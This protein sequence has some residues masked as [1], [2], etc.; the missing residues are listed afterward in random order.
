MNNIITN[1]KLF[2]GKNIQNLYHILDVEK[3]YYVLNNNE[4][5]SYKFS[6][7][8]TTRNKLMIDYTGCPPVSIFKLE[9]DGQKLSDNYKIKSFQDKGFMGSGSER[10]PFYHQEW[11]EQIQT[12][13]IKNVKKYI[14]KIILMKQKIESLKDISSWFENHF[15]T[16]NKKKNWISLPNILKDIIYKYNIDLWVQDG[17]V[18]KKDDDYVNSIINYDNRTVYHGFA[19]YWRTFIKK[20]T[21]YGYTDLIMPL[22]EN[23]K[24][25]D[26]LVV[27]YLYNNIWVKNHI[28]D[29]DKK[30]ITNRP[31]N[32][33]GDV[34]LYIFDFEYS[35]Q[36]IIKTNNDLILLKECKLTNIELIQKYDHSYEK[37]I[38]LKNN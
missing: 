26:D 9:L 7:I 2:E 25:I 38:I 8:S 24:I 18:I 4:I 32:F 31:K 17:S 33:S 30:T 10:I 23:N 37:E 13:V 3:L 20:G 15:F 19:L 36:D 29:I 28:D 6:K 16:R 22:D 34:T 5:K 12:Q 35:K 27:G 11:E 21:G 1:F 14:V